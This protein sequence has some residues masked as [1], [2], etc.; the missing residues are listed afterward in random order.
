MCRD[1]AVEGRAAPALA[2]GGPEFPITEHESA[3]LADAARVGDTDRRIIAA[4]AFNVLAR[5]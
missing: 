1:Q 5:P 4:N 2:E 3:T